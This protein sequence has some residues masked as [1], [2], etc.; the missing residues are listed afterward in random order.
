MPQNPFET[1]TALTPDL[2]RRNPEVFRRKLFELHRSNTSLGGLVWDTLCRRNSTAASR[3]HFDAQSWVSESFATDGAIRLGVQSM[4][5]GTK[6]RLIFEEPRFDGEREY[7]YR[8]N[9]ELSHLIH[10]YLL[11]VFQYK[12]TPGHRETIEF[13][14]TLFH[15]RQAGEGFTTLGN[16][17]FYKGGGPHVQAVE[18][19]AELLN[20]F[21]IDPAYLQRYLAFLSNPNHAPLRS[22]LGLTTIDTATAQYIFRNIKES[23]EFFF[24]DRHANARR[25]SH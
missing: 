19:H 15:M 5:K 2:A 13:V 18:D 7:V 17:D 14:N 23:Y 11:G 20:M 24:N 25:S 9:H 22:S 21:S 8:F 16:L 4:D 12:E 6:E 1:S 10:P 3:V